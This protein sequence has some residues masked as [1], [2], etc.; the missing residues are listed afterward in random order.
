MNVKLLEVYFEKSKKK[1]KAADGQLAFRKDRIYNAEIEITVP[2]LI[3]RIDHEI[4]QWG[5]ERD[6]EEELL[7]NG[8][9]R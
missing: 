8:K 2:W 9:M 7:S 5:E 3:L 6:P 1:R 4:V